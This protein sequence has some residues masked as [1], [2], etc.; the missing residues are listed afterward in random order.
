MALQHMRNGLRP[1]SGFA[2]GSYSNKESKRDA[3]YKDNVVAMWPKLKQDGWQLAQ[4]GVTMEKRQL[5]CKGCDNKPD[6][7]EFV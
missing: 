5:Y 3:Y 6:W 4:H 7:Y 2:I 1:I